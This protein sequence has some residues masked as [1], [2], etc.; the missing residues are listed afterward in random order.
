MTDGL[1]NKLLVR[2][3]G[4]GLNNKLLVWYSGH[5]LNS[6]QVKV[7]YSDVRYSDPHCNQVEIQLVT[8]MVDLIY[9]KISFIVLTP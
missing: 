8:V 7:H 1:N 3:S 9:T 6:E 4:H 5:G 2:H